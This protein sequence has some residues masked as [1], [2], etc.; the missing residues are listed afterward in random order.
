MWQ[1]SHFRTRLLI[2]A[3]QARPLALQ[4]FDSGA[5]CKLHHYLGSMKTNPRDIFATQKIILAPSW[6][7]RGSYA[8]VALPALES[9]IVVS[10][11]LNWVWLKVL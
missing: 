7:T 10:I 8:D 5:V 11:A 4:K 6:K 1:A 3:D 9:P 2:L